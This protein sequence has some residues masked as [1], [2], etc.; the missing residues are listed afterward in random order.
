MA[1]TGT[2]ASTTRRGAARHVYRQQ[3]SLWQTGLR[4]QMFLG[5]ED[6]IARMQAL[7]SI[8]QRRA[9]EV[10]KVQRKS[11]GPLRESLRQTADR[12][13]AL[14]VAYRECGITMTARA[15]EL[16]LSVSRII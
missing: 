2:I 12:P 1:F 11:A 9:V 6:F 8:E 3:A 14:R 4:Q 7:A 10:P 16:G 15:K 13:E 5:N